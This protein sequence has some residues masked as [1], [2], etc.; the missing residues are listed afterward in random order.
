MREPFQGPGGRLTQSWRNN[1][2]RDPG[3]IDA[4]MGEREEREA[5]EPDRKGGRTELISESMNE[6]VIILAPND[7][8]EGVFHVLGPWRLMFFL[9]LLVACCLLL[10][11]SEPV[12]MWDGWD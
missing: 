1:N 9:L 7:E 5:G 4:E 11:A 3:R 10:E 12:F 6:I 2:K 8:R